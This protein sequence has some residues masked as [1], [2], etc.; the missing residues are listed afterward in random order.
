MN[1]GLYILISTALIYEN[2][3]FK[4]GMSMRLNERW[5]DYSDTYSNPRYHCIFEINT[6]L[7]DKQ[8]KFLEGEI[9]R[10]TEKFRKD[11]LGNEWSGHIRYFVLKTM[12][13][14]S[15]TMNI[16]LKTMNFVST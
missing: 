5:Y 14:A 12:S 9:L 16:V 7:T 1:I 3:A 13:F 11:I 8:V 10:A 4:F 6:K 15:K 2:K